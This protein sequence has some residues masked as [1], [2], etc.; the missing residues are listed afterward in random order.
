MKDYIIKEVDG[1][2]V[3]RML[4]DEEM[5]VLQSAKRIVENVVEFIRGMVDNVATAIN[6]LVKNIDLEKLKEHANDKHSTQQ[7]RFNLSADTAREA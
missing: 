2:H 5:D 6:E 4:S 1:Y 3:V 7:S